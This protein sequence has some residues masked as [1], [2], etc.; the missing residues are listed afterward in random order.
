VQGTNVLLSFTT[1]EAAHYAVDCRQ[2]LT[3]GSWD[4]AVTGIAGTGGIVTVTN[5]CAITDPARFYRVRLTAP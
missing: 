3:T 2:I 4:A 1:H 5:S